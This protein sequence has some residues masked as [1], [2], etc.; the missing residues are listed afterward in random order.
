VSDLI[1]D[2]EVRM[3]RITM[4]IRTAGGTA[5]LALALSGAAGCQAPATTGGTPAGDSASTGAVSGTTATPSTAASQPSPSP[6]A[7]PAVADGRNAAYL[8]GLDA[9]ANTVTFDP[10]DF[11]TGD[12]AKTEWKKE[13]PENPDGPENDYM[14]VNNDHTL[15]T[16]PVAA[17]AQCVVLSTLGGTDTKTISFAAFPA[18]ITQQGQGMNL[19]PPDISFLPFCLTV[20]Q[21][22]VVK[23]EEQFVP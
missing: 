20:Q 2:S 13:H 11:L 16:L 4:W 15:Q 10:I 3:K 19:T 1:I 9:T 6:S 8:T 22:K 21:G 23:I 18:F 17:N 14:I 5:V 7:A 12:A